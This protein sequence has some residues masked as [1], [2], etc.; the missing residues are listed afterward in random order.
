MRRTSRSAENSTARTPE[1]ERNGERTDF[2]FASVRAR[3]A[4]YL[5]D[6]LVVG[7]SV[8]AVADRLGDSP[9]E[10]LRLG[11]LLGL[12]VANLYHVV[13]EGRN[14]QTVGKR[15]VGIA[16]E[17]DDGRRCT[18]RAATIRTLFRF[19]DWLP[20]GYLLGFA[21]IALT[22][23]KKRLGDVAANTVVVR[24]RSD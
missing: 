15:A 22:E 14:G 16:V 9:G 8:V 20:V 10:R 12:A 21:S 18:P 11:G 24:T 13:L 17:M 5:L 3:I 4:A 2:E 6:L 19:V 7:S 1:S 23:R